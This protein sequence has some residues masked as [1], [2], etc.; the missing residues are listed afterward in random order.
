MARKT[1]H[2]RTR[3]TLVALALAMFMAT[4]T[5]ARAQMAV[6][7]ARNDIN[8]KLQLVKEAQTVLNQLQ[9]L[10][11][12]IQEL[13]YLSTSFSHIPW[14]GSWLHQQMYGCP[15]NGPYTNALNNP[16]N[17]AGNIAY[18]NST[19]ASLETGCLQETW[20]DVRQARAKVW[21]KYDQANTNAIHAIGVNQLDLGAA[22]AIIGNIQDL[23]AN[24][25]P[26]QRATIALLQKISVSTSTVPIL[27]RRVL[28]T[29]NAMLEVL[30][31]ESTAHRDDI[32]TNQNLLANED[33]VREQVL[34]NLR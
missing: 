22:D 31:T 2:M 25:S 3:T 6:Y 10:K 33:R 26:E 7:D 1:K 21:R 19:L 16:A 9:Q 23:T 5:P 24:S 4:A 15:W 28:A 14:A 18:L 20:T 17:W 32:V 29:N 34:S 8:Q 13:Q 12:Q 27:L 11:Y 30:M